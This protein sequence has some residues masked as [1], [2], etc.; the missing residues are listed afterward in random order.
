[1]TLCGKVTSCG[2]VPLT[3]NQSYHCCADVQTAEHT[4]INVLCNPFGKES[5]RIHYV[6]KTGLK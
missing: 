2:N 1:M 6:Y 5:A 4:L 3:P